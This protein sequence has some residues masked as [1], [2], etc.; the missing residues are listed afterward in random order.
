MSDPITDEGIAALTGAR[1]ADPF[2]LLGLHQGE[3]GRWEVRAYLPGAREVS[4][5]DAASGQPLVTLQHHPGTA[6]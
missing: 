2:A 6:F 5:I 1:H 4:V 3:E